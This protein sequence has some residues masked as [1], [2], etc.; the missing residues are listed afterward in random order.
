MWHQVEAR[1]LA[2]RGF[3]KVIVPY[4]CTLSD[5][6]EFMGNTNSLAHHLGRAEMVLTTSYA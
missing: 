1:F 6:L 3:Y 2:E 5:L 4:Q